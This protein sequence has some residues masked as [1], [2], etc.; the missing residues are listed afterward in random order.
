V[1][2]TRGTERRD[3]LRNQ[4]KHTE[5]LRQHLDGPAFDPDRMICTICGKVRY[6]Y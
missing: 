4:K 1:F 5:S 3:N 2:V 6:V